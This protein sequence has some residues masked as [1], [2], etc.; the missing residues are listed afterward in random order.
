M[1]ARDKAAEL[2]SYDG[3]DPGLVTALRSAFR[4]GAD[5]QAEQQEGPV[6]MPESGPSAPGNGAHRQST[7]V[8]SET[9]AHHSG[10][11]S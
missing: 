3:T 2:Y 5:W 8:P 4:A 7:G 11:Q 1:S 9:L 6:L 10:D